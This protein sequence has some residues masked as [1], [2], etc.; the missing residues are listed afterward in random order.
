MRRGRPMSKTSTA[1]RFGLVLALAL[2]VSSAVAP[3][4]FADEAPG[5][6]DVVGVGSDIAQNTLDFIA[7]GD[8]HGNSGYTSIGNKYR[9]ISFDA[10]ADGN[11]RNAFTDPALGSSVVLNPTITLRAGTSP[12]Q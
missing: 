1:V 8:S 10:T 3:A 4:A 6:N 2:G 5:P 7:G 11:G 9:L 12:V